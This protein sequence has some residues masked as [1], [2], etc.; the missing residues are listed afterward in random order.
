[1]TKQKYTLYS[2]TS[3]LMDKEDLRV[4]RLLWFAIGFM[5][6]VVITL[7]ITST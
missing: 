7:I 6:A 3:K 1:M 4:I 2:E 5:S